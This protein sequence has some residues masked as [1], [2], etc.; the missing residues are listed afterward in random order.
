MMGM[1]PI[2]IRTR[3]IT[4]SEL[5]FIQVIVNA[6]WDKGRT[7]I[8]KIL[9][10]KWNWF[11]PNGRHKD[12]ACREI[13]LT[14]HRNGLLDLP[15]GKHDGRNLKRNRSVPVVEISQA[16]VKEKLSNLPPINLRL[17]RNTPIEPLYNSLIQQHHY[18]G[19]K[20]I[21]GNHLKYI[22][23]IGDRPVACLG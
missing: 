4:Q 18:L 17:A 7:Q 12:M 1:L 9:C 22:A 19:Y 21:V 6:H 11:Q 23:F 5:E 15:P 2:T 20:Q 8:S 16:S 14:L 13:L 10:E 3:I